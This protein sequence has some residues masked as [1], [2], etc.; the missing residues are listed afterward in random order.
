MEQQR[1]G[2]YASHFYQKLQVVIDS[3]KQLNGFRP[4]V[5]SG[6]LWL[7]KEGLILEVAKVG[8]ADGYRVV[9]TLNM[10]TVEHFK[11]DKER[12]DAAMR[13]A[14]PEAAED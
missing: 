10:D 11:L 1:Q 7:E 8:K 13:S 14:A 2:R 3:E 5:A 9:P 6:S 4:K 12:L